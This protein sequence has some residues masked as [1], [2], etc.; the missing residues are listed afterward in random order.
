MTYTEKHKVYI[1]TWREK[2]RDAYL[3][4]NRKHQMTFQ[5]KKRAWRQISTEFLKIGLN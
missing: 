3:A 1:A 4:I 2:H 5:V